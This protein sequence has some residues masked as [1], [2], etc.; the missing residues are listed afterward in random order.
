[1]AAAPPR[2]GHPRLAQRISLGPFA[3]VSVCWCTFAPRLRP[4]AAG[5]PAHCR[6][7]LGTDLIEGINNKI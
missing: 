4:N 7:P 1:V 2:T 5:T 6:F 3:A